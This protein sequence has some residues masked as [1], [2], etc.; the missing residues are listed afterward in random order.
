MKEAFLQI[1]F[2]SISMHFLSAQVVP[3]LPIVIEFHHP[4]GYKD[5]V[6]IGLSLNADEGFDEGFDIL[7]TTEM[8]YPLDA[9][10]YDPFV[11]QDLGGSLTQNLKHSYLSIPNLPKGKERFFDREFK[12]VVLTDSLNFINK[13]INGCNYAAGG[14]LGSTYFKFNVSEIADYSER[15]TE[16]W[17]ISDLNV[18]NQ[19]VYLGA[20]YDRTELQIKLPH[21]GSECYG[22]NLK[23]NLDHKIF[24]TFTLRIY[25]DLFL[26]ILDENLTP[27]VRIYDNKLIVS[28]IEDIYCLQIFETTGR[29]IFSEF[30]INNKNHQTQFELKANKLYFLNILNDNKQIIYNQNIMR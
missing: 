9:R 29:L 24:L 27:W 8:Q 13:V 30:N 18:N 5:S 6:L 25:N 14:G 7:D 2:L 21:S 23:D 20:G 17:R 28:S 22:L 15:N 11:R 26:D 16:G 19:Q 10:I 1:V 3:D 12:V 4:L